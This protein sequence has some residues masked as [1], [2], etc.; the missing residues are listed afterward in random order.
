[1]SSAARRFLVISSVAVLALSALLSVPAED[2][3]AV[4]AEGDGSAV[5]PFRIDSAEDLRRIGTGNMG[6][7]KHYVQTADIIFPDDAGPRIQVSAVRGPQDTVFEVGAKIPSGL[8]ATMQANEY[9]AS[10]QGGPEYLRFTIPNN[11]FL[12][13]SLVSIAYTGLPG[14][15]EDVSDNAWSVSFVYMQKDSGSFT[16]PTRGNFSPIGDR[17]NPFTG[18]YDGA[19]F[20]IG[21]IRVMDYRNGD[22]FSGLFGYADGAVIRNVFLD[23]SGSVFSSNSFYQSS[24]KTS[25]E[26]R[27]RISSAG[28]ICAYAVGTLI[29][30][31]SSG[32]TVSSVIID[33]SKT[34][35]LSNG[36]QYQNT[37]RMES[38]A[39]GIAGS[40]ED[41]VIKSS[42]FSGAVT[43]LI[44]DEKS[45]VFTPV[46]GG[47]GQ[48]IFQLRMH[49]SG[50][51]CLGGIAGITTGSELIFCYNDSDAISG[52]RFFSE[53][54]T[55]STDL[56]G[57]SIDIHIEFECSRG[58]IAGFSEGDKIIGCRNSGEVFGEEQGMMDTSGL[59]AGTSLSFKHLG[60]QNSG[61]I[62]G[63]MSA[64][65]I[66]DC[67]NT[68]QIGRSGYT[69]F[70][71]SPYPPHRIGG[72][73]GTT[74][75][76]NVTIRNCFS[77]SG[78][79]KRP[80]GGVV[81]VSLG[82]LTLS[83]TYFTSSGLRIISDRD[84]QEDIDK[85]MLWR[86]DEPFRSKADWDFDRMWTVDNENKPRLHLR[87]NLVFDYLY[88]DMSIEVDGSS[89]SGFSVSA[90]AVSF[91]ISHSADPDSYY[92]LR[93]G[94]K[95]TVVPPFR[96]M[97]SLTPDTDPSG[98][99]KDMILKVSR[100]RMNLAVSCAME[101]ISLDSEIGT[102]RCMQTLS[103][104]VVAAPGYVLP[105]TIEVMHGKVRL[106][107]TQYTFDPESG[108]ILVPN[109]REDILIQAVAVPVKA[110]AAEETG[111]PE[112]I[113][114]LLDANKKT[115]VQSMIVVSGLL[116]SIYGLWTIR[117]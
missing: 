14:V 44:F 104:R 4:T 116:V 107:P 102:V 59:S 7:D 67:L 18:T 34:E 9:I 20:R 81:G 69:N 10:C 75:G 109:V 62:A 25:G 112:K 74:D 6:M 85:T 55:E 41:C 45:L 35:S 36:N 37:V 40:A 73:S 21:G 113:A 47:T 63:M 114:D 46:S 26:S 91:R 106:D 52:N 90:P 77:D 101:N 38:F 23:G 5:D 82:S 17:D 83:G 8:C 61:G 72:I 43:S 84:L 88:P 87:Y 117:D 76:P 93:Q 94:S 29:E 49:Q 56:G 58:G 89:G 51:S 60:S 70:Q 110:D 108:E 54:I 79:A 13:E 92:I 57:S 3:C 2:L 99:V 16:L 53:N 32:C 111:T 80:G 39:G 15:N 19:G 71:K 115:I 31:C 12:D 95:E 24:T 97:I 103:A 105:E 50:R 86:I 11:V 65:E 48:K 68:G 42:S 98:S 27:T 100:H 22:S 33:I 78:S 96:E 64:T 66:R 30:N 1:M 28:S